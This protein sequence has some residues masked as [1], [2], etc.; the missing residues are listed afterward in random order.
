MRI[1][2]SRVSV[3]FP[4]EHGPDL[5]RARPSLRFLRRSSH[6]WGFLKMMDVLLVRRQLEARRKPAILEALEAHFLRTKVQRFSRAAD[7][8]T[9]AR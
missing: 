9:I 3:G 2:R 6:N 8:T 7:S 1:F 5:V 4:A